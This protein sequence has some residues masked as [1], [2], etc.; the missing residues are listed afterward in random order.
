MIPA[1][2]LTGLHEIDLKGRYLPRQLSYP[3]GS[4]E[5]VCSERRSPDFL[6][7]VS[8]AYRLSKAQASGQNHRYYGGFSPHYLSVITNV[9]TRTGSVC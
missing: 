3:M 1:Q 9:Q 6:R 7:F 2:R 5:P 4:P 8:R